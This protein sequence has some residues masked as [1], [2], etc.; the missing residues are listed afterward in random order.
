MYE[1]EVFFLFQEL[2]MKAT[3]SDQ[4]F[5]PL[6]F[7]TDYF[8]EEGEKM[9]TDGRFYQIKLEN[10]TVV[11]DLGY[12]FITRNNIEQRKILKE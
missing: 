6:Y 1:S 7:T 4:K 8:W 3:V 11:Y 12:N 9:Y 10:E 2:M 5:K